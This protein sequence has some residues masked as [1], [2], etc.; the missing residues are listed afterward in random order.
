MISL[1]VVL[2]SGTWPRGCLDRATVDEAEFVLPHPKRLLI[3]ASLNGV[4]HFELYSAL[5]HR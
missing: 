3:Q 4:G 5:G 2:W 1:S